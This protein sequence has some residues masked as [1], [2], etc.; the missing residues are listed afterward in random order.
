MLLCGLARFIGEDDV[1]DVNDEINTLSFRYY[2]LG[3]ALRIPPSKLDE[4]C[5]DYPTSAGTALA[6]VILEWLRQNYN[7][8]KH[9]KPT[10]KMLVEAVGKPSG[11]NNH[12]LAE[13]I[14]S[15]HPSP[16]KGLSV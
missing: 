5:A 1:H 15:K 16:N 3:Q 4:I 8:K 6:Q 13:E 2:Q 7:V 12:C 9:G 10:W 11:G 14:A